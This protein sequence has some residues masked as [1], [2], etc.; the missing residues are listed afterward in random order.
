M[1]YFEQCFSYYTTFGA[2]FA[3]IGIHRV[4]IDQMGL[5][6]TMQITSLSTFR[7]LICSP[8]RLLPLF[9]KLLMAIFRVM[10]FEHV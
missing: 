8:V 3:P 10:M 1:K 6:S 7:V 4:H 2:T 5:S 9:S